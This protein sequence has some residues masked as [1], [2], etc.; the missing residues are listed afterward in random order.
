[1][2]KLFRL[3]I[4]SYIVKNNINDTNEVNRYNYSIFGITY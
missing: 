3:K 4:N 1:M 2:K